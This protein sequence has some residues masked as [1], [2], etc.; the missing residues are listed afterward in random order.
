MGFKNTTFA[1]TGDRGSEVLKPLPSGT[2]WRPGDSVE[3]SWGIRYNHGGGYSYRLCPAEAN[4]TEECFQQTPLSF[5]GMPS[6]RW[7]DGKELFFKGT[8]ISE[9]TTPAGSMWAMNPIPRI[10]DGPS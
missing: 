6:F 3:V 9:G 8:Y 7:N 5:T 10:D 4:L 1:Q 2:V